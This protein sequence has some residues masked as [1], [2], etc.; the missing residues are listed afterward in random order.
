MVFKKLLVISPYCSTA[1]ELITSFCWDLLI[2]E[3]F[4]NCWI[5]SYCFTTPCKWIK[6]LKTTSKTSL[7]DAAVNKEPAYL[8]A[9]VSAIAGGLW[10][11]INDE[12]TDNWVGRGAGEQEFW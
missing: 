3:F 10:P 5:V 7:L 6:S 9:T 2:A 12:H 1:N 4:K 11:Y 8:P